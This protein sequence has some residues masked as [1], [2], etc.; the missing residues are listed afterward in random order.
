M[1]ISVTS[2]RTDE[3]VTTPATE[4]CTV[5]RSAQRPTITRKPTG[6]INGD[7]WHGR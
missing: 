1:V 4:G 7:G 3:H 5:S 6:L 2:T